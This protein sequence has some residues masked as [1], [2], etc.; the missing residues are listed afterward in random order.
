MPSATAPAPATAPPAFHPD[1]V[2]IAPATPPTATR[3]P[4][5]DAHHTSHAHHKHEPRSVFDEAAA[6]ESLLAP[7]SGR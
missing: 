3:R 6:E 7:S 2:P 1:V 4:K 5:A